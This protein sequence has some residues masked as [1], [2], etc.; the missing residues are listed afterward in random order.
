M[1]C[2]FQILIKWKNKTYST[3]DLNNQTP[4]KEDGGER[5]GEASS[6]HIKM[7]NLILE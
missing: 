7:L 6:V 3:I 1:S 2:I 5:S 4:K